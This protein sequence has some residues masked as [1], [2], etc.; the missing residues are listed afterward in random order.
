MILA[1]GKKA[2]ADG[3]RHARIGLALALAELAG[4]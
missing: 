3:P 1:L 2:A 4:E